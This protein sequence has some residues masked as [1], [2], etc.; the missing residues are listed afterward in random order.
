MG[1]V[2]DHSPAV[3]RSRPPRGGGRGPGRSAGA[4][5]GATDGTPYLGPLCVTLAPRRGRGATPPRPLSLRLMSGNARA[6]ARRELPRRMRT[7]GAVRVI[8]AAPPSSGGS[9]APRPA[10]RR[11]APG[12]RRGRTRADASRARSCPHH[13]L[14]RRRHRGD[15]RPSI[16]TAVRRDQGAHPVAD[17][18][19][20]A[21]E[22]LPLPLARTSA[23]GSR[24][25][26][27]V[28][29]RRRPRARGRPACGRA[30]PR[31]AATCA[32]SAASGTPRCR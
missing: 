7:E 6:P 5:A 23:A 13:D 21:E 12:R 22:Q 1:V 8:R 17:E 32:P 29:A 25:A 15:V 3:P 20:V 27:V 16:T 14:A 10:F 26:A 24:S 18:V 11:R 31:G 28:L 4:R 2:H 9:P 19:G 30:R